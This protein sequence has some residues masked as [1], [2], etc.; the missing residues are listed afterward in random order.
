[1]SAIAAINIAVKSLGMDENDK[2]AFYERH[3]GRRSLRE[4]TDGQLGLVLDELRRSGAPKARKRLDGPYAPKLQALWI[5][6]YNLGLVRNKTDEAMLGFI[7]RQTGIDHTRFLRDAGDA[8]KAVEGLKAWLER[9]GVD[10][11]QSD[12][13]KECVI[14]AQVKLLAARDDNPDIPALKSWQAGYV[15]SDKD[16]TALMQR[17]GTRIRAK[18]GGVDVAA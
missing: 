7:K 15:L 3:T 14:R 4:M 9:A 2:R 10:W 1:M 5:S 6:G 18:A 11:S 17:L 12:N 8:R 13:P 16:E